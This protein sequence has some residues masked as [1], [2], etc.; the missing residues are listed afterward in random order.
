M[1]F[2]RAAGGSVHLQNS[3]NE[4]PVIHVTFETGALRFKPLEQALFVG[5][6]RFI[7]NDTGLSAEYRISQVCKGIETRLEPPADGGPEEV[8]ESGSA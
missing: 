7:L 8:A 4:G 6:G 3:S 1:S 2:L 5:A